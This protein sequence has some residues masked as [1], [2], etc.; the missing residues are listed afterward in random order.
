[1]IRSAGRS[2]IGQRI[3]ESGD[4]GGLAVLGLDRGDLGL[5]VLQIG[6]A[7]RHIGI[8]RRGLERLQF[9]IGLGPPVQRAERRQHHAEGGEREG[10]AEAAHLARAQGLPTVRS[11]LL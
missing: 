3:V 9:R 10:G 6:L 4:W 7:Q 11:C 1:M 5:A 8:D 2:R